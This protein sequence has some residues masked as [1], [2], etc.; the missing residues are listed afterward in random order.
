[1]NVYFNKTPYLNSYVLPSLLLLLPSFAMAE[2]PIS[3][4]LSGH[5]DLVSKYVS[6]GLTNNPEDNN[7]ALQAGLN[8]SYQNFYVGYWGST[9]DYSFPE[10]QG[11]RRKRSE[12]FEHDFIVGYSHNFGQW[13]GDIWS[14]TYYYPGGKNT[15]SNELGLSYSR[16]LN[17]KT[18]LNASISTYLYDVIYANQGDTFSTLQLQHQLNDKWATNIEVAASRFSDSGKYENN[19]LG[20]TA[21][22]YAFRY[23]SVGLAYQ[24]LNNVS[25]TGQYILGGYDRY[26]DKQKDLGVFGISYAF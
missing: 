17:E 10:F 8:L 2:E 7:I 23:A 14:A 6:R 11:E 20:V 22:N 12:Q 16:A 18:Q 1:M 25:V 13:T 15:T 26:D 5:I 4:E 3:P 21:R 24:L 9:L 19:E